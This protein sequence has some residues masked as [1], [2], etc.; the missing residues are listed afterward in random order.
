MEIVK[1]RKL[2]ETFMKIEA[3]QGVM[4]DISEHFTFFA[5][6]YKFM[7]RYKIG[8]WDGKI[9]LLNLLTGKIY[10]GLLPRVLEVCKSLNY[11]VVLMM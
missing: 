3:D 11:K 7:Q 10:V 6:N 8:M 9:R 4:R 2:N 1:I 5:D